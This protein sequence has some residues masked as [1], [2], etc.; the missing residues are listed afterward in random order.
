MAVAIDGKEEL[1]CAPTLG[2][3][4]RWRLGAGLITIVSAVAGWAGERVL[5]NAYE[6]IFPDAYRVEAD[7]VRNELTEKADTITDLIR[8][9]GEA[10]EHLPS[11]SPERMNVQSLL[12]LSATL[13]DEV[14]SLSPLVHGSVELTHELSA[15]RAAEKAA[16][17]AD[18]GYS[19]TDDVL[20]PVRRGFTV[21]RSGIDLGVQRI[22]SDDR[23]DARL[24]TPDVEDADRYLPAGGRL[25]VEYDGGLA[26]VVYTGPVGNGDARRLGFNVWCDDPS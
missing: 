25:T 23:I 13:A 21:C 2:W 26:S 20:V 4:Q 11:A 8:E 16:G 17:L 10:V 3:R 5:T 18:A 15:M 14:R 22:H 12:A 24:S 1:R 7:R 6:T 9:V 19:T